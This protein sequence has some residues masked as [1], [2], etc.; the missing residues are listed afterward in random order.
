MA[1]TPS[2]A[3]SLRAKRERLT[4]ELE[5]KLFEVPGYGSELQVKYRPLS[6]DERKKIESSVLRAARN[7]EDRAAERG[8]CRTLGTACLAFYTMR[9]G[10][11]KLLNEAEGLG[12][13]AIVWGD[14]RLAE[15][16]G[17]EIEGE[18]VTRQIVE[19]VLGNDDDVLE[20]HCAEVVRWME[21][22]RIEADADF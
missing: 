21:R 22:G 1:D 9:D 18:V 19:Y 5:P 14:R 3:D 13:D 8:M 4:E 16:F 10:E 15:L 11:L 7:G 20:E 2:L 17:M 12:E 6:R